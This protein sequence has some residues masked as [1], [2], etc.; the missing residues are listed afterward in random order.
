VLTQTADVHERAWKAT[1][2]PLLREHAGNGPFTAEDYRRHVDGRRRVDGVRAFLASRGIE[3]PGGAP[4][5]PAGAPTVHG[6]ANAKDAALRAALERD[7]VRAFPGSVAFLRAVRAD[8]LRCGVV[9][10]SAN[11]AAILRAAGLDGCF[12]ARVDGAVARREGLA[13]KPAPDMFLAAAVAL[14]TDPSRAAVFEDAVAGVAAARAGRFGHVVGVDRT[15]RAA[16]LVA[17]GA[18]VVVGDLAE[19]VITAGG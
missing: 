12:A 8:G 6:V 3:L 4:S 5:D 16:E 10:S 13:G 1:F 18:D 17:A 11:C 2:D 7:G 15:G 14:D 9:S 19:L